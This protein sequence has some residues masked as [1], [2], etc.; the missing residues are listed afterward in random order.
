MENIFIKSYDEIKDKLPIRVN[1]ICEH[2][3]KQVNKE[4]RFSTNPILLCFS[5]NIKNTKSK[6]TPEQRKE[7]EEKRKKTLIEKYGS[8]EAYLTKQLEKRTKT[9]IEKYGVSN[10]FQAEQFKEKSKK[11]MLKKYG[12][13]NYRNVE[14]MQKT[15][16][17]RYGAKTTLESPELRAK[18]IITKKKLYGE[19]LEK[20]VEKT[21]KT[22]LEIYGDEN[23]NSQEK[24]KQT[25]LKKYGV[26]HAM[27]VPEIVD[28]A[29]ANQLK[30]FKKNYG[31]HFWKT[32]EFKKKAEA[33]C[34]EKFG[35]PNFAQ[36]E[37]F[38]YKRFQQY[39]YNGEIFDSSWELAVWIYAKDHNEDIVHE[40][41][42]LEYEFEGKM[43]KY[44]PDFR[45]KGKLIE[46]KG[47]HFFNEA[48]EMIN[49]FAEEQTGKTEA[50]HQCGLVN[51]VIFYKTAE[52]TPFLEYINNTYGKDYLASFKRAE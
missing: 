7:A 48:G 18:T 42:T 5:C 44:F 38:R 25:C 26:D 45:Y 50:K 13:E 8:F 14:K 34:L 15:M 39:N 30:T 3:G 9:N 31:C 17:E 32:D 28:K 47:D 35:V 21:K 20:I 43:Y 29:L 51:N 1:F 2:C 10:T 22:K 36:T 4:F 49:P 12:N 6:R 33:T 37:E 16:T 23:Y 40:P 11:T 52:V 41:E 19:Y 46:V 24:L 27:K